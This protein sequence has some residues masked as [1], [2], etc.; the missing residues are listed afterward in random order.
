MSRWHPEAIG[1][2]LT[3][4]HAALAWRT[5]GQ[6]T[7]SWTCWP[8]NE[9]VD[10]LGLKSLPAGPLRITLNDDLVRHW[11]IEAP[12][13]TASLRELRSYAALRFENLFGDSARDW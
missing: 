11:V 9:A 10:L 6:S 7:L 1:M 2:G 4:T 5:P 3:T 12:Q 13:G 8:V